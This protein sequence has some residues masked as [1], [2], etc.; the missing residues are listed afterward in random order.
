M[1]LYVKLPSASSA[2][3]GARSS[4]GLYKFYGPYNAYGAGVVG[5]A[6]NG[7]SRIPDL[8]LTQVIG[9]KM[10]KVVPSPFVLST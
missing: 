5:D 1:L 6:V 7:A 10:E 2:A 9:S 8:P 3:H 4:R